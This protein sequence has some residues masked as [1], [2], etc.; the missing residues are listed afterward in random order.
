VTIVVA[1]AVVVVVAIATAVLFLLLAIV[2]RRGTSRVGGAVVIVAV[3]RRR[4]RR[5]GLGRSTRGSQNDARVPR[6]LLRVRVIVPHNFSRRSSFVGFLTTRSSGR[7]RGRDLHVGCVLA[8]RRGRRGGA[9]GRQ[10]S[11]HGC[12]VAPSC[13]LLLKRLLI[14][15]VVVQYCGT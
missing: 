8:G 11:V 3:V 9:R 15:V 4:R 12:F 7:S 2:V 1:A 10:V 6:P 13:R 5:R 14:D